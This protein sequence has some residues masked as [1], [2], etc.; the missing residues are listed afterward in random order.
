V[1]KRIKLRH[2]DRGAAAR[3]I[4]LVFM[5]MFSMHGARAATYLCM[6][7][8]HASYCIPGSA[9]TLCNG[10]SGTDP[11]LAYTWRC[12]VTTGKRT[13]T[14][15][16]TQVTSFQGEA[17]CLKAANNVNAERGGQ[18][19]YCRITHINEIPT[20]GPLI[21]VSA[22]SNNTTCAEYCSNSN[23]GS[24]GCL[25]QLWTNVSTNYWATDG[26]PLNL[27]FGSWGT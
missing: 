5:F 25:S 20:L 24:R 26:S 19:C 2:I 7:Q 3:G 22:H 14:C 23:G 15:S 11:T 12:P 27:L 8:P 17:L 16:L 6:K 13:N 1:T 10:D 18:Y 21:Y 9:T 4:I